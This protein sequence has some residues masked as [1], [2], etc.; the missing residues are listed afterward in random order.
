[1]FTSDFRIVANFFVNKRKNENYIPDDPQV[2]THVNEVLK[3]L[4]VMTGDN[5][6]ETILRN[7]EGVYTMCDV[8]ERLEKKGESRLADLIKILLAE[9]RIDEL[10]KVASDEEERKRLYK[11][12]GIID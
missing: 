10:G 3:L 11:E 2:I 8:A 7:E 1:M 12:Y 5:R 9:N 4:S 6:Y